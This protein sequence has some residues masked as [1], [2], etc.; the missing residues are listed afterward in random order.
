MK[1]MAMIRSLSVVLTRVHSY[2]PDTAMSPDWALSAAVPGAPVASGSAPQPPTPTTDRVSKAPNTTPQ[3]QMIT[4]AGCPLRL[5]DASTNASANRSAPIAHLCLPH[6]AEW[7][8]LPHVSSR[9]RAR[10]PSARGRRWSISRLLVFVALPVVVSSCADD[11]N[12]LSCTVT[13]GATKSTVSLT[14]KVGSSAM[15]TVG[16]YAVTFTILE[17]AQL[18]AVVKDEHFKELMRGTSGGAGRGGGGSVH[19]PD[20]QLDYTCAA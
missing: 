7:R 5:F 17:G 13:V 1:S 20:G 16:K 12:R 8:R 15:A 4:H 3:W 19:T 18:T 6:Q 9:Y 2:G 10:R 14:T 11:G